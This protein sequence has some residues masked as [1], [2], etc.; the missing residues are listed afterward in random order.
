MAP[1][2]FRLLVMMMVGSIAASDIIKAGACIGN[3]M[4]LQCQNGFFVDIQTF[5]CD[6]STDINCYTQLDLNRTFCGQD[7]A[8]V[9]DDLF[10]RSLTQKV[11]CKKR[12]CTQCGKQCSQ[13]GIVY[14]T[15]S[16]L[17]HFLHHCNHSAGC[18]YT[19]PCHKAYIDTV[20]N[21]ITR[22]LYKTNNFNPVT[23]A[24]YRYCEATYKCVSPKDF[25]MTEL[26]EGQNSLFQTQ[27]HVIAPAIAAAVV[28]I[29]VVVIVGYFLYKR[30]KKTPIT[31]D[32]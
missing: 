13:T 27:I 22:G 9:C 8:A 26:K 1:F 15:A 14:R 21:T 11:D 28:T 19:V 6:E 24:N 16:I 7:C 32:V 23:Y 3:T 30:R 4:E 20:A 18:N 12:I 29:A 31:T 5:L 25:K 2:G 10:R 17:P